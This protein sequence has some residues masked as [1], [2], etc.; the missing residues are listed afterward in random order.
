MRLFILI[1]R[2]GTIIN[3]A[4]VSKAHFRSR[5]FENIFLENQRPSVESCSNFRLF[6]TPSKC[7]PP[8]IFAN[9]RSVIIFVSLKKV[10]KLLWWKNF[11]HNKLQVPYSIL[12][13]TQFI[14]KFSLTKQF[15]IYLFRVI[16][17]RQP[18]TLAT[19]YHLERKKI[20]KTWVAT[21]KSEIDIWLQQ[22]CF[23]NAPPSSDHVGNILLLLKQQKSWP[24]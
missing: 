21:F 8:K 6:E 20:Y 16:L 12:G 11:V 9:R 17:W 3:K 14:N 2:I 13:Q 18:P 15:R 4:F 1:N 23:Q 19:G 24:Q 10:S 7:V 22:S 5:D